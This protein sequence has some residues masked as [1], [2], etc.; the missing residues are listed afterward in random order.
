MKYVDEVK[1]NIY[2]PKKLLYVAGPMRD[3]RG[4]YWIGENIRAAREVF[5]ELVRMGY[6]AV[7]PH[8][9]SA[10]CSGAL[11]DDRVWL[12]VDREIISRCDGVVFLPGW[13]QSVGS[14]CEHEHAL[15]HDIPCFDWTSVSHRTF[16]EEHALTAGELK[17][18][19]ECE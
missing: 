14:V 19:V 3:P 12:D 8:T 11:S 18:E 13:P 4:E 15:A 5:L 9:Q 2:A 6:A 17:M 7:C 16:L 10:W 1:F